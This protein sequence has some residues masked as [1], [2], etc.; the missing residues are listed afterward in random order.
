MRRISR[1][2]ITLDLILMAVIFI[3]VFALAAPVSASQSSAKK[4]VNGCLLLAQI[5]TTS[6]DPKRT[7]AG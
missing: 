5:H 7:M 6:M 1:H 3:T 2:Q 4:E